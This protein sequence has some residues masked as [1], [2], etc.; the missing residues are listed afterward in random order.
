MFDFLGLPK[1][2]FGLEITDAAIRIMKLARRGGKLVVSSVS[3]MP[4]DDGVVHNGDV[5][6]GQKLTAAIMEARSRVVGEKIKTR[7]VVVSLPEN[8]A[9]LQVIRMP[10]LRGQDLRAAV[11]FE[12]EN[13]IPLP[14]EKVYLDFEIIAADRPV[15]KDDGCEIL[16]TALPREP[17]D[18]RVQAITA[19]G[20]I[21]VAMELE[22]QA[23]VRAIFAG[24]K[25]KSSAIIIQVGDAKT[26]LVIY[27]GDSIRFTFSIPISNRYFLETI[28]E[29]SKISIEK[30]D[31]LKTKY[32]I[33][34]IIRT[35]GNEK[36]DVT[37]NHSRGN[38]D[39]RKIFEALIPGLVDFVQQIKKCVQYYQ[40]HDNGRD[41]ANC[42][43]GKI[44]VCGSGSDL[45]GL[46]EFISLKLDAP[47]ERVN[48]LID[49]ALIESK[50]GATD[51][52]QNFCAYSV[53]AGLAMRALD[54]EQ[55]EKNYPSKIV[56]P[57]PSRILHPRIKIK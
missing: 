14:L 10:R 49:T 28:A 7:C 45:K 33:E 41:P 36:D 20:L 38:G 4:L 22:S 17:I 6:D 9:F 32:G 54:G 16:V 12:A 46:D 19:A 11:T 23:V 35:I 24:A 39:Q 1:D 53:V 44:Y 42:L 55:A 21:P 29:N 48:P 26:N 13:Y 34:E 27:S 52:R 15:G 2:A 3:W 37:P 47:V 56:P 18:A 43:I 40:T 51:A 30:A 50:L 8:K 5:K 25:A 31:V 57:V